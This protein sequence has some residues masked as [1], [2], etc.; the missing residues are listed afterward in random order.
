MH[1]CATYTCLFIQSDFKLFVS[2]VVFGQVTVRCGCQTLKREWPCQDVQAA[3]RNS[4][5]D[6]R[7]VPKSQFGFALLSCSSDC[8]TKVKPLDSELQ[9]RKPKLV[10]VFM[11]SFQ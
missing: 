2:L 10:E 9:L 1:N 7:D 4:G 6:P 3:Y 5:R 11:L 8:K